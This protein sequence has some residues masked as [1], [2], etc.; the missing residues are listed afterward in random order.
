PYE[1]LAPLFHLATLLIVVLIGRFPEKMGRVLAAYMGLNYLVIALVP[2]M[3]MTEKYGHVIHWGALVASALLG[4]TWIVVAI[5]S[6]L[7]TSYADVPPSRYALLPLALLA[8]WSPYRATGA[9]V[10]PDFDPLLLLASPDY[11]LTFCLTTPVFLFLLILFYPKVSPFAYRITAF[12]G[13]LYGLFNMTHFFEPALRWMG[14]LHLPL[15]IIA[16]YALMLPGMMRR[17]AARLG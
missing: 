7:E 11:G 6:G 8:F 2:T 17:R 10:R 13:L 16:C 12:N 3:G 1:H 9:G 14:V 15:L 5:R 4:V